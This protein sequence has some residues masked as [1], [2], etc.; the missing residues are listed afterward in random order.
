M[1]RVA[2]CRPGRLG[3]ALP[4]AAG[5]VRR[6]SRFPRTAALASQVIVAAGV[7]W[8]SRLEKAMS[9]PIPTATAD[10]PSYPTH[11]D[12]ELL[13][14]GRKL[15]DAWETEKQAFAF[16][17]GVFS[18][19]ADVAKNMASA[20]TSNIVDVIE[21]ARARTPAG[22]AVKL[23]A[24]SWCHGG[25]P[26]EDCVEREGLTTDVLLALSIVRD[27]ATQGLETADRADSNSVVDGNS[28]LLSLL[29]A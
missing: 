13:R 5:F 8:N 14:L 2:I 7:F 23:R 27:L 12:E 19:E 18:K 15:D 21:K 28:R 11:P 24:L 3:T 4:Q 26:F 6:G 17:K 16:W 10:L 1:G 22:I 20:P 9:H 29:P 25:A